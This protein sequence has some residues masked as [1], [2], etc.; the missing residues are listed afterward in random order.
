MNLLNTFLVFCLT[1]SFGATTLNAQNVNI[2]DANFKAYLVGNT[3]INI[4]GDG[5]IQVSEALL[6][7][8]ISC[9]H[10]SI[11]ILIGIE[12]FTNLVFLD[13]ESNSLSSLDVSLLTSLTYLNCR[14]NNLPSLDLTQN[15]NLTSLDC[16]DNPLMSLDVT[17]NTN[18]IDFYCQ[19]TFLTSLDVTQNTSLI[20]FWCT[21]N[22]ISS[23]D[24]IQN[25]N[26][27]DVNC[28]SNQL[29]S[30]DVSSNLNLKN[31]YCSSNQL[32]SLDVNSN[33]NLEKLSCSSNQLTSLDISQNVSLVLFQGQGNLLTNLDVKNGNNT[34]FIAF[35]VE[36]NPDLICIQ[37]DSPSYSQ[38]NWTSVDAGV[39]FNTDC[40]I[41]TQ[42]VNIPDVNLKSYLVN[43][44]VNLNG[45]GEIQVYEALST[46]GTINCSNLNIADLTGIEAFTG[47]RQLNC[48]SNQLTSLDLSQNTNLEILNCSFNQLT[49]LILAQNVDLNALICSDNQLTSLV[50]GQSANLHDL[51]C[52]NNQ[53]TS[54]DLSSL[55]YLY[56]L[57]CQ[58]N[59]LTNMN[60]S[61]NLVTYTVYC[62]NN[63][64]AD[65]DFSLNTNLEELNCSSNE[66][67]SL[68]VKNGNNSNFFDFYANNN[69]NLN[70]IQVDDST[71][72]TANWT[73]IDATA[74]FSTNCSVFNK[75]HTINNQINLIAYP[76]PT[77]KNITLDF[78]KTYQA[79]N[80][81]VT[82]L[83]GQ[84]ILNRNLENLSSTTLELKGAAGV[85]FVNLQTEEGTE[86]L[87]IIKE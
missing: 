71:Y 26:L 24:I 7:D 63:Q 9:P 73:N 69:P 14:R 75:T 23:L 35:T 22:Y 21:Y 47:L 33:I 6:S 74:I 82:N 2:P 70:C 56:E 18:L 12:A 52:E 41:Y 40:S 1:L 20:N 58:N 38:S 62:Q 77:T 30:L 50:F 11:Y 48:S 32:T 72:S 43:S 34:N 68:N 44:G 42:I 19:A 39:N 46:G 76:N 28:S 66:L 55:T 4:N 67:V 78:G 86:I 3:S 16:S 5:E 64:F 59:Q 79:A 13:C 45:D 49:N 37:V 53:L 54:L 15:T 87:K 85:Y 17:Q 61:Q 65:L 8:T 60:I 29:T 36:N 83:T 51:H 10:L 27:V 25:V 57:Y 80:I 81:Q 31:I 84:V